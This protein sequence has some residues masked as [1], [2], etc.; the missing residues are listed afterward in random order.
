M[1]GSD[2]EIADLSRARPRHARARRLRLRGLCPGRIGAP[3]RAPR[4]DG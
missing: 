3:A 1:Q 2:V 4:E